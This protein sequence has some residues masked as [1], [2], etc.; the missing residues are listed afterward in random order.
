MKR[1]SGSTK[2]HETQ[3]WAI[4]KVSSCNSCTYDCRFCYNEPPM[5]IWKGPRS[6]FDSGGQ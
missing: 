5:K 2:N 3:E 6:D 4:K 1:K